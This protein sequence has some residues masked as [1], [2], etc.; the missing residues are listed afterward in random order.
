MVM[1]KGFVC[2]CDSFSFKGSV[3]CG[4]GI[5]VHDCKNHGNPALSQSLRSQITD[6]SAIRV[7]NHCEAVP[8]A[9]HVHCWHVCRTQQ[10]CD[11]KR[12]AYF[13]RHPCVQLTI[14]AITV[15]CI[16]MESGQVCPWKHPPWTA[17]RASA[18]SGSPCAN[19][20]SAVY[21]HTGCRLR[22][23]NQ[24]RNSSTR[25]EFGSKK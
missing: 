23:C 19:A 16:S 4:S 22:T 1:K 13:R 20:T 14:A 10:S 21:L 2:V 9:P 11:Q 25:S 8:T 15:P 6:G 3:Q 17:R 5:V 12:A 18:M 7:E 24:H